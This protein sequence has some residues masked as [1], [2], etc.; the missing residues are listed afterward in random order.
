MDVTNLEQNLQKKIT[1]N[2][3]Q[4]IAVETNFEFKVGTIF[5]GVWRIFYMLIRTFYI[6]IHHVDISPPKMVSL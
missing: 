1:L 6:D 3:L 2:S 5:F 4:Y